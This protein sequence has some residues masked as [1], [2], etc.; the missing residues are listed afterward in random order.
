[1]ILINTNQS[2][3]NTR[4]QSPPHSNDLFKTSQAIDHH[5][6][7]Q[8]LKNAFQITRIL[9]KHWHVILP[10]QFLSET[11][12]S[13]ILYSHSFSYDAKNIFNFFSS[14][15]YS[16]ITTHRESCCED[17][18]F[19]SRQ[20]VLQPFVKSLL[21]KCWLLPVRLECK[22]KCSAIKAVFRGKFEY[23]QILIG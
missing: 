2:N 18:P 14:L 7:L 22:A 3:T 15:S 6:K 9:Q 23:L 13:T 5:P 4:I 20:D 19:F 11:P 1:M 16:N 21:T 10:I 8:D 17:N 12:P